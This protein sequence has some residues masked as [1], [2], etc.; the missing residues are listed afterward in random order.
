MELR[1]LGRTGL[2]V[3]AVGFGTCQLR[4]VPE[5]Q[6]IDTLLRGFDLGVNVVHTAP[7]YEG[8]EDL[9]AQAVARSGRKVIVASQGYDVHY[10][11]DGPVRHFEALFEATCRRLKTDRLDLYGIACL[12]DREAYRENVWGKGGMVDFLQ[13]KKAQGRLGATFCTTHGDPEYIQKVVRSGAFDAVMVAYN[14][15]GYHLL[16][17]RPPPG[18]HFESIPRNRLELFPLCRELDVGLMVMKPLAGGLLCAGQAFPPRHR[19]PGLPAVRA[20][21][22]LRSILESPEVACVLPGTASVAEAEENARAGHAPVVVPADARAALQERVTAMQATVC[23]RCGACED[24]CSQHLP[25]SWLFRAAYVNLHPSETFETWDDVE[26]FRLHPGREAT[27]AT[28]PDVTCGCPYGIDVPRSL[29]AMHGEMVGLLDRGLAAA[30]KEAAPPACGDGDFAA[31]VVLRDL[32]AE[33]G[34]GETYV[35]RLFVE[36]AGRRSWFPEDNPHRAGVA[37]AVFL[38]GTRSDTVRLRHEV[39]PGGRGHFVFPITAPRSPGRLRLR[40]RVLGEHQGYSE[41]AGFPLFSGEVPV[42]AGA[43][44]GPNGACEIPLIVRAAGGPAPPAY[45]VSW[46][47]HNLPDSWPEG[48]LYQVY[49][50]VE[51]RGARIWRAQHPEGQCVDLALYA[52]GELRLMTRVPHDVAPG[53]SATLTFPFTFPAGP[54]GEAWELK[55]ALVEQNVA[56]F[57]QQGAAA[58]TVRLRR[59]PAESGPTAEALDAWRRTGPWSYLPSQ[60]ITHSRTGRP[61][62]LF[63]SHARGCRVRDL[64][65]HEWVDYVMGW[66]SALLGYA[67]PAVRQAVAEHL[68]GGAILGLP[69]RL[70][71]QVAQAL[72]EMVPCAESVLFGKNGSDACTAAVRVARQY[73]GRR[74][75]LYS[76]YHGWQDWYAEGLEPG[77]AAPSAAAEVFRFPLNDLNRFCRL[78]EEHAGEVAAVMLEPAAQVEGV[79]GPVRDADPG[80]LRNVA[81]VCRDRGIVLVFDEI[82]TGFR[83][84]QGSVQKATGVVPDL[85]CLGKALTSGLPLS[86]LVGRRELMHAAVPRIFYHPTFKGEVYSLAAAAAAL[87]VYRTQDVPGRV[88][89]F[90]HRLRDGVNRASRELGVAGEMVGLPFRMVYRFDEPDTTRRL[91]MRTLLQQELLQRG[92]LTFRGFLLPSLAH[93]EEEL[94]LTLTAFRGALQRVQEVADEGSFARHLEVPPVY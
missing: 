16:S 5:A 89:A 90:G 13:R 74:K 23:S 94:G 17:Y 63:L 25:I 53:G 57:E 45:A 84:A 50:R 55:L 22:V 86:A 3:S 83:Y 15:L 49:V 7:D 71:L 61:Y 41:E 58:L 62:P 11:S 64:E 20:G 9:V 1:R 78:V 12:D 34:P 73:T 8:A 31:R 30:P 79:D 39:H 67:H 38:D 87:E 70:E 82:I 36:N 56:W 33:L 21:D 54:G 37:L 92:V 28:C 81:A 66:G 43:L 69:H 44:H 68:D 80:F 51:N 32:P 40:L 26:Y 52:D 2:R 6:A 14:V 29:T 27:C 46:A 65:G 75:V 88:Q 18:R 35:C 85:A 77:L 91:L 10:N 4:L 93:G 24:R 72:G 42:R 47:D 60:G 48:G 59:R 76:G 19:W